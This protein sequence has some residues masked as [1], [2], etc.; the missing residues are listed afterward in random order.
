MAVFVPLP[1]HVLQRNLTHEDG[2]LVLLDV[3][4]LQILHYLQLM[5]C[6]LVKDGKKIRWQ[7]KKEVLLLKTTRWRY[8]INFTPATRW[9]HLVQN[10]LC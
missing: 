2:I 6:K 1:R 8:C 9:L 5:L 3:K 7:K 4:I 10:E